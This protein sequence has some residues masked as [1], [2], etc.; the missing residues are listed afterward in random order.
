MGFTHPFFYIMKKFDTIIFD[1]GGV[2]IDLDYTKTRVA[3]EDLGI[4]QFN[5]LYSQANQQELFDRFE[6]GEI[7]AQHFINNLLNFFDEP[8]SPN[9]I[10]HAWNAMILDFPNDKLKLLED[11]SLKYSLYLLSNTNEI[12]LPVVRQRFAKNTP[13]ALEDFFTKAYFS[14]E[15]GLRKPTTEIFEFVCKEN[16]LNPNT[17]LFIDDSIQ[18]IEG[19]KKIGLQTHHLKAGD[20]LIAYFS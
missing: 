1:L 2:L 15:I 8:I 7:S 4:S 14:H 3:F 19:A 12:H 5:E 6:C 9:K 11:L 13:K 16:S 10:V 18:H 20:N 17:T